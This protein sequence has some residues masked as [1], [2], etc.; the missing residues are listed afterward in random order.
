[1]V[2][3]EVLP[4][5]VVTDIFTA[6]GAALVLALMHAVV[7]PVL[8]V[9]TLPITILTLGLFIFII[10]ALLF[11]ATAALFGGIEVDSFGYA[12]LGSLLIS[13]LSAIG[14][15]LIQPSQN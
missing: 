3:A 9:L 2:V 5:I 1:M 6:I 15:K 12:L 10:N 13:I 8:V 11:W 7:R 14:N 4:G